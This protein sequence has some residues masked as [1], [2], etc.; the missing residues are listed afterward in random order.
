M[1][2]QPIAQHSRQGA[3]G[4]VGRRG[5]DASAGGILLID[6]HGVGRQP[7]IG[8]QWIGSVLLPWLLKL[9]VQHARSP[10]Y[11]EPA[12]HDAILRQPALDAAFYGAPDAGETRIEL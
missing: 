8:E 4:A 9:V 1:E 5:D 12:R 2:V 3:C 6:R 11:L 7:V 10:P